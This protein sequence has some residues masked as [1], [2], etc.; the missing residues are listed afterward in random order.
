MSLD[1]SRSFRVAV[2]IH[3]LQ[4]PSSRERG[5]GRYVAGLLSA[6]ISLRSAPIEWIFYGNDAFASPDFDF[7][8]HPVR[9]LPGKALLGDASRGIGGRD[10]VPLEAIY[11][12]Q[13]LADKIDG[14]LLPSPM[15]GEDS[16]I[17]DLALFPTRLYSIAYDLIPLIYAERSLSEPVALQMYQKRLRNI[18]FA[19]GVFAISDATRVDAVK[20]L[21]VPE[22]KT[23]TIYAGISEFFS[24]I[25]SP[26][27]SGW[28]KRLRKKFGI[29]D[30]FLL[31]NGG[32]DWRKNQEG[33]I[34][35]FGR[36]PK[37]IGADLQLVCTCRFSED[38]IAKYYKLAAASGVPREKLILTGFVSDDEL[39]ALYSLCTLFVYPSLHEGF[40]LPIAEAMRCGAPTIVADNSSLPEVVGDPTAL[41]VSGSV[42]AMAEKIAEVLR[43]RD[44][45]QAMRA[46]VQGFA[47]GFTWERAAQLLLDPLVR[48]LQANAVHPLPT[49][50]AYRRLRHSAPRTVPTIG[51][52]SP[53]PGSKSGIADTVAELIPDLAEH[54]T[55]LPVLSDVDA[56]IP[57]D[58]PVRRHVEREITRTAFEIALL[59]SK[60]IGEVGPM[61]LP[62]DN[63]LYQ[64]GDSR[65]HAD[66]YSMMCRYPGITVLHDYGLNSLL[67]HIAAERSDLGISLDAELLHHYVDP[68]ER[69]KV[70]EEIVRNEAEG[71]TRLASEGL[72]SNRRV[73]SRSLGVIVPSAFLRAKAIQDYG[74]SNELITRIPYAMHVPAVPITK[75]DQAARRDGLGLPPDAFIIVVLG[76]IGPTSGSLLILDAFRKLQQMYPQTRLVF[77]GSDHSH[78]SDFLV[79]IGRGGLRDCVS[80]ANGGSTEAMLDYLDAADV[81]VAMMNPASG[82]ASIGLLQ[83]MSRGKACLVANSGSSVDYPANVCHKLSSESETDGD[84]SDG[85]A[86][87]LVEL[88][89]NTDYRESLAHSA[90]EYVKREH[91]PS[92]CARLYSEF[93]RTVMAHPDTEPK[94]RADYAGRELST[95]LVRSG[96]WTGADKARTF[97]RLLAD[98]LRKDT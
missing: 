53:F 31:Y 97:P 25:P 14:L 19:D 35:A 47:Q 10:T 20:L 39:R 1:S 26:E 63:L 90:W 69:R 4:T 71:L 79:E 42:P 13:L 16:A 18:R 56:P 2:D 38:T 78:P 50:I 9:F 5:I 74:N 32:N 28:R 58:A 54:F 55:I 33:L 27:E 37:D 59:D 36:L 70:R 96:R 75:A 41:F 64:M 44:M 49:N 85:I 80:F 51:M 34:E 62:C 93:Y 76:N 29:G 48:D 87:A 22:E 17:P 7:A 77:V 43:N 98:I 23:H 45:V 15:E 30:R 52:L 6:L 86:A 67:A 84:D 65:W 82:E 95:A 68:S 66:T 24:P 94:R 83:M 81:G 11:R 91:S 3:A 21:H 60:S 46:R 89:R 61:P 92:Y 57:K 72:F 88:Y 73:F 12:T 8:G 40:G